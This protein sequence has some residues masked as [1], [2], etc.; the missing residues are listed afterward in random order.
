MEDKDV[1]VLNSGLPR[2]WVEAA[3]CLMVVSAVCSWH[4]FQMWF[5][6]HFPLGLAL[7]QNV[8]MVMMYYAVMKIA[9]VKML[10]ECQQFLLSKLRKK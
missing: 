9:R 1:K 2:W 10:D 6:A 7:A 8:G 4:D 5:N 3:F